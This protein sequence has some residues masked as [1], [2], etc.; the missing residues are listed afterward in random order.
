MD[1]TPREIYNQSL[2][3]Y[4]FVTHLKLGLSILFFLGLLFAEPTFII[5]MNIPLAAINCLL[6]IG[7]LEILPRMFRDSL[8]NKDDKYTLPKAILD[9]STLIIIEWLFISTAIALVMGKIL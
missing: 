8:H 2:D 5:L 4:H 7:L 1:I 6:I 3:Y 9:W